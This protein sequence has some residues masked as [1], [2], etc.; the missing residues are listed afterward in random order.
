MLAE[1]APWRVKRTR[2]KSVIISE[3][4]FVLLFLLK[5]KDTFKMA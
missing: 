1:P 2:Y 3:M 4:L 5:N